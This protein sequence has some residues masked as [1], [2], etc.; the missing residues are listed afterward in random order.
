MTLRA[1]LF[2]TVSLFSFYSTDGYAGIGAV[3]NPH[4]GAPKQADAPASEASAQPAVQEE[5]P[6]LEIKFDQ[7]YVKYERALT[8][9]IQAAEQ[10][11]PGV[12]YDIISYAPVIDSNEPSKNSRIMDKAKENVLG[13]VRQIRAMGVP[14]SRMRITVMPYAKTDD[15]SAAPDFNKVLIFVK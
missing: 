14:D 8:Q 9:G 4:Q 3:G 12:L 13:V 6:L 7:N 15:G 2:T 1:V 10:A 11:K 5:K